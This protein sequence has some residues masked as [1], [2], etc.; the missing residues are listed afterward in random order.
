[1]DK[2][3]IG[4]LH[5]GLPLYHKKKKMLPFVSVDGPGEQYDK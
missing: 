1:M 4:H 5:N 3:T 2:T